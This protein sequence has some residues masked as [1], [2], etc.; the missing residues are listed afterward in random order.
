MCHLMADSVCA[1]F[2]IIF[3]S[4]RDKNEI[5]SECYETGVLHRADVIFG[6]ERLFVLRVRVG[7]VKEILEEI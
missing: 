1:T 7:I 3:G 2:K 4:T 6:Y 5:L